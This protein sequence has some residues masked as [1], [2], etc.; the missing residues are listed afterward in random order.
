[1]A[2]PCGLAKKSI[3]VGP[4]S[5]KKKEQDPN[6]S[7]DP[8]NGEVISA[9]R[10]D[11]FDGSEAVRLFPPRPARKTRRSFAPVWVRVLPSR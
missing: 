7:R 5:R 1:M 3:N 6:W 2:L 4:A 11:I 8:Q 10:T 9:A